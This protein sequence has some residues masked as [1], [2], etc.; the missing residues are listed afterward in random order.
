MVSEAVVTNIVTIV[1]L[2]ILVG[3]FILPKRA[4]RGV[5]GLILLFLGFVPLLYSLN[6]I[7]FT[8]GEAGIIKYVVA[9]VVVF[10]ARSLIIEGMQEE[11]TLRWI[12][13]ILGIF[14]IL[15]TA[16]P[17]LHKLGALTFTIP[18]YPAIIDHIVYIIASVFLFIGMFMAKD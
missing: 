18:E 12:S 10:T 5:H 13:I 3:T 9:V 8:F 6:V 7:N 11:G 16:I 15:L 1:I 14:I 17:A 4:R 2:L